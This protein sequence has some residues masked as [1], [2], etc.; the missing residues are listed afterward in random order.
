MAENEIDQI[1]AED[2]P[3][4]ALPAFGEED[5][6]ID[7]AEVFQKFSQEKWTILKI[8]LGIAAIATAVAFMVPVRYTSTTSFVPPAVNSS[9]STASMVAGQL[10]SLG[11]VDLLGGM[12]SPGD[13]YAGILRSRSIA[14][15]LVKRFDLMSV[16]RVKK[17]S[18]AEKK[19][20]DNT[21]VTV[22]VKS[23]IVTVDVTAESPT[24]AHDLASAYMDALR[25]TNGRLAL[26]QSSQRRLFF[27]Q[28]LEKEKDD[29]EDAEVDLKKT[30]EQSGLIAPSG[31]TESEI[32][33]IADTQAQ[34]AVREVQLAALRD[35][36]TEQNPE[37]IRLRSEIG[38]LQGQLSR[39][40]KGNGGDASVAAIPTSKVPELQLEYVRKE[41]EVKY[42][43]A[44]FDM[45]SKQYEAARLDE[46]RDAPVLQVLDPASYPDTKSWPKRSY[47]MLGGLVCGFLGGCIWVLWSDGIRAVRA[48][49]PTKTT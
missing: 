30:E 43:E 1:G 29:L 18:Q 9:N 35:S 33:T 48:L 17:E 38:D 37:V 24:L 12:K 36:A 14:G 10:S 7:L 49:T 21:N 3:A 26:G 34:M 45:L 39:L 44:L 16:Y 19:L 42:H 5:D 22:D 15:E 40:Q 31:Q 47:F 8:T 13:L 25:E 23:S 11:A 6:S 20:A 28:Q 46:A 27:G 32:K 2:I 41:R 4:E